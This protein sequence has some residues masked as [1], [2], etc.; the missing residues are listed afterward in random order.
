M[1]PEIPTRELLGAYGLRTSGCAL[2]NDYEAALAAAKQMKFPVIL[3]GIVPD[4]AHKSEAGVIS[5]AIADERELAAAYDSIKRRVA[6]LTAEKPQLG[7]VAVEAFVAHDYEV[8]LGAKYDPTFG[9]V[10]LFGLGGIFTE[11]LKD[12]S[13]RIAP[14]TRSE[15]RCMMS[16][17]KAFPVFEKAAANGRL[18]LDRLID[19]LLTV[20]RIAIDL[21]NWIEALDINPLALRVADGDMTVLDAKIHVRTSGKA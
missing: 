1:L 9:P 18:N 17:L 14:I 7:G 20:S 2:A 19:V 5:G 4:L 11:V 21:R 10:V 15:A 6:A 3:K 13:V 16:E 12:Y 8:I